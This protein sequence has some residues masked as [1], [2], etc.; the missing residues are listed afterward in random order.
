MLPAASQMAAARLAVSRVS[1]HWPKN[2]WQ[3][4]MLFHKTPRSERSSTRTAR[5]WCVRA[6]SRYSAT[7]YC[8][9]KTTYWLVTSATRRWSLVGVAGIRSST[10]IASSK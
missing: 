3:W 10:A 2:H 5:S 4:A 1:S 7:R 9:K 6:I 8:M